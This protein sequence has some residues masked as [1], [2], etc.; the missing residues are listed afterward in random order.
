MLQQRPNIFFCKNKRSQ[1]CCGYPPDCG[2]VV[3]GT[4]E[5]E[6]VGS[7]GGLMHSLEKVKFRSAWHVAVTL[8]LNSHVPTA[9]Q[10][11]GGSHIT[12]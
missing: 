11:Q 9:S 5:D 7:L 3:E 8:L 1:F 4:V 6:V 12:Y 2:A 10:P